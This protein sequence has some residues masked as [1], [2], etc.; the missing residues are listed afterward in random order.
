MRNRILISIM[1]DGIAVHPAIVFGL[2]ALSAILFVIATT[3]TFDA[4]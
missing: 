3:L 2:V 1:R 4:L